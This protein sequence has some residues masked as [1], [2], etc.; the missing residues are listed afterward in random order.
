AWIKGPTD[1]NIHH[2]VF[3]NYA[4]PDHNSEGGIDVVY[5][6]QKLN[7]HN[8]TF[9]GGGRI[10]NLN[11]PAIHAKPGRIIERVHSNAFTNFFLNRYAVVSNIGPDTYDD[12]PPPGPARMHCAD[13][14]LLYNPGAAGV[15][16]YNIPV[17]PDDVTPIPQGS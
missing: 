6:T 9:D 14:N 12:N 7:I 2:N 5:L 4:N 17:E 8:N 15:P 10:G 13:Y 1:C 16:D 11:V 3:V